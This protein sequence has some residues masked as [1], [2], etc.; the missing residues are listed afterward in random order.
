M[1]VSPSGQVAR[2][3]IEPTDDHQGLSLAALPV[4]VPCR[5]ASPMGFEPT[6]STLTGWR[7]LQAAPRGQKKWGLAPALTCK[8]W[9]FSQVSRCLSPFF[10]I[11]GRRSRTF[12]CSF[13][14]RR[15]TISRSPRV[16]C[17]NRTRLPGLVDRCHADRPRAQ[18]KRKER[19]LNPQGSS[20]GRF[21]DGCRRQLA[22]PSVKLRRQESNLQSSP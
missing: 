13:K 22:C 14:D 1:S 7:A 3:G 15:P 21:R 4:C 9:D 10:H 20:L 17:G 5:R 6:I 8:T 12:M 16:P 2:V 11:S 19:E 18:K